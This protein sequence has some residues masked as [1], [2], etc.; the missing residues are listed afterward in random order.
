[1]KRTTSYLH[2][3]PRGGYLMLLALVFGSIFL[4][5]LGSLSSFVLTE[6][7][8]QSASTG[9]S[10][11]LAM[12]EA[13]LEYYR[14]HLAHF[15]TDL[16]NGTGAP[17][18]YSLPF[19]DPEGGTTG[20]ITLGI[21]GH[22]SCGQIRSIDI[23]STG[24]PN[25]GSNVSRTVYAKYAQPTVAEYSY[26]LNSSDWA[27]DE[28]IINGP[29]HTNG[30]VRL[31]G[32]ANSSVSS[33]L[34]TWSCTASFGCS[35]SVVKPGVFGTGPHPEYW[36]YPTPQ[37]DFAAIAA[38][39]TSLKTLALAGGGALYFPRTSTG[40]TGVNAGKGYHLVFN[41]GGTVT[42][43]RVTNETNTPSIPISNPSVTS[44]QADYSRIATETLVNTYTLS[45]DCGL[46]FV[47]DNTWIEGAIP[48][49]VTVIAANVTTPGVNPNIYLP[50]NIT[51]SNPSGT[52]GLTAIASNDVLIPPNSPFNMTLTGVFIAQSGSF[53]RNL[54]PCSNA[55]NDIRGALSIHGTTVAN[56][57]SDT[58]WSYSGFGCSGTRLSGYAS[59]IDAFDRAL[60]TNPP[61]F[62]P[63]TSSIYKFV[64]WH[65]E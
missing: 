63:I 2:G 53:G 47:E 4:T 26:V 56:K 7:H 42:V 55:P 21:A 58:L 34:S 12:A 15:P 33:S 16:Q 39:F 37:V 59:R 38:D 60:S 65:E 45:T 9:R 10:K 22:M 1:M 44:L 54:Y 8:A 61:P 17:G 32:V 48:T 20:T 57:R 24:S 31:D 41:S 19:T 5:V 14:W 43:Y 51:Y 6:N 18:P 27:S 25:D 35:P 3:H 64:D 50:N 62:T 40:T 36:S 49:S 28:R 30:G 52:S 13:G 23:T 29:Y 11:A 46:I